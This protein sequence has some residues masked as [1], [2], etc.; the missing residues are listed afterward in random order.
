LYRSIKGGSTNPQQISRLVSQYFEKSKFSDAFI[1][2]LQAGAMARL[3][4]MR[5]IRIKKSGIYTSYRL[6]SSD[7]V[8]DKILAES[9]IPQFEA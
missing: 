9:K 8:I 5:I 7:T 6:E 1:N 3:I 4:E 2:S